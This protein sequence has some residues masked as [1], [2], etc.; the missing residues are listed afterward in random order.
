MFGTKAGL[1]VDFF[2]VVQVAILPALAWAI[3][4]V[5]RGRVRAHA[6]VMAAAFAFFLMSVVAFEVDVHLFGQRVKPPLLTLV[7]HLCLS[8]P[9]VGLWT[10][11]IVTAKKALVE[12]ARHRLRGRLLFGF[13]VGTVG[14]GI[15]LYLAT[16]T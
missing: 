2:L 14:T 12:P 16:F 13:I 7:I 1:I 6:K 8:L 3:L 11:Q 5:R 15:W 4:L 9:S 10:Y